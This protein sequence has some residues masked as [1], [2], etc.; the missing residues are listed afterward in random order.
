MGPEATMDNTLGVLFS[1][2]IITAA[3]WGA[4][5]LQGWLYFRKYNGRDLL[6]TRLL[7]AFIMVADTTQE[8]LIWESVYKYVVTMHSD[9]DA[10]SRMVKTALIQLFFGGAVAFAVQGFYIYRIF[11]PIDI[12]NEVSNNKYLLAG[13]V[14]LLS[15]ASIAV[16]YGYII[17]VLRNSSLRDLTR[18]E[19]WA[20]ALNVTS[21]TTDLVITVAM[22]W[23]LQIRKTG[24][25][26]S[27]DVLN[28]L[29]VF[30]FNT[31][32]LTTLISITVVI[33][34]CTMPKNFIYMGLLVIR[35]RF[36]TNSIL[37]T[38]NSR[39][40]INGGTVTSG[41]EIHPLGEFAQTTINDRFR[42]P[43][44]DHESHK[45]PPRGIAIRIEKSTLHDAEELTDE[46]SSPGKGAN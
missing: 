43:P 45:H 5:S 22:I 6:G 24:S 35:D 36:Y 27:T 41:Q 42:V 40:Y 10:M 26:Q 19:N 37:V 23:C 16:M 15:L 2:T 8:A 28:R 25:R 39:E 13:A 44:V 34:L 31:G 7:I 29:I 14:S 30:T 33:T 32:I 11:R 38:L 3:L 17:V 18:Q 21:A 9:P 20:I 1:V 46:M 12:Q 4:G